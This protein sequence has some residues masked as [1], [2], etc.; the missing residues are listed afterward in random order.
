M[1]GNILS[2]ALLAAFALAAASIRADPAMPDGFVAT[3]T[4]DSGL[5]WRE[6]GSLPQSLS[7]AVESVKAAM[8]AQGYSL[9]HDIFDK[10][11]PDQRLFLFLKGD[12]EATIML[13]RIDAGSSGLSWGVTRTTDPGPDVDAA[14]PAATAS[15]APLPSVSTNTTESTLPE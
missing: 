2:A 1:N 8:K 9:R 12:E 14:A 11:F 13:W 4:D 6:T 5:A 7:N 3:W 10:A 15:A